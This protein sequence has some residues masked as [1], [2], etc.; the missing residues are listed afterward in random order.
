[1]NKSLIDYKLLFDEYLDS[2]RFEE[3]PKALYAPNNY[4]MGLGGKRLRPSLLLSTCDLIGQ[5]VEDALPAA[6][7]I[8]YFHNFTLK[9]TSVC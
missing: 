3:S 9:H 8:E 5:N 1:M 6:I 4:I 7:A 2:Q